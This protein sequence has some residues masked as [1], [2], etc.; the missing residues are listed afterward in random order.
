MAQWAAVLIR[1]YPD[2]KY[3]IPDGRKVNIGKL[4]TGGAITTDICNTA[5]K[6]E[7]CL[8]KK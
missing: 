3:V 5:Q 8:L 4:G 6:L 7:G 1:E 2:C